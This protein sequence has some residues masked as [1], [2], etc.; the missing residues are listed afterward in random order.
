MEKIEILWRKSWKQY[1][2]RGS[3]M[4]RVLP[5][6]FP[7]QDWVAGRTGA[8]P[9]VVGWEMGA[10]AA[11]WRLIESNWFESADE[12]DQLDWIEAKA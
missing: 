12:L 1:L 7:A 4:Q 5:A 6:Y 2:N 8:L 11:R 3:K 10:D 9:A